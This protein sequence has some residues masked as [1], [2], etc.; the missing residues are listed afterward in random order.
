MA[1]VAVNTVK[2]GDKTFHAG[3][4][5]EGLSEEELR[6]LFDARSVVDERDYEAVAGRSEYP[7][8]PRVVRE[9]LE[10]QAREANAP[11]GGHRE[12]ALTQPQADAPS[13]PA[14]LLTTSDEAGA[15]EAPSAGSTKAR[16][17]STDQ[18]DKGNA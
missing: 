16:N 11:G 15:K 12:G 9:S 18:G 17:K 4:K 6:A 8:T 14:K 1:Y 3:D 7:T 5:V 2:H 13:D 10:M